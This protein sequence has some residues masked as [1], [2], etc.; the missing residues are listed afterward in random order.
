MRQM[1][2]ICHCKDGNYQVDYSDVAVF[3]SRCIENDVIWGHIF[4]ARTGQMVATYNNVQG[5]NTIA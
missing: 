1:T 2:S 3:E 4:D 5:L